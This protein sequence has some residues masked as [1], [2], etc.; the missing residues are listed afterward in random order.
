M[1]QIPAGASSLE[2]L[3]EGW[4]GAKDDNYIAVRDSDTGRYLIN[5]GFILSMFRSHLHY[6]G[7]IL[8]YSGSDTVTERLNTTGTL[9]KPLVL[10]VTGHLTRNQGTSAL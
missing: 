4:A 9:A 8:E 5:G 10:E 7:A 1:A 3:Q 6:A 2:I